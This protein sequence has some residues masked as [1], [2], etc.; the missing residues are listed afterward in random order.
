MLLIGSVALN[1]HLD[2]DVRVPADMD[3]VC[4]YDE[5]EDYSKKIP[6]KIA[7]YPIQQG[8]KFIMKSSEKIV[9]AEIAWPDSSSEHLLKVAYK[10][11]KP[12]DQFYIPSLNF[13]YMLKMSHKYLKD[14]PHFLKTMRDIQLM[15]QHGAFIEDAHMEFFIEREKA[16]Y[17]YKHPNLKVDKDNFFKND[18]VPYTYDHDSIHEAVKHLDRPAYTYFIIDGAQVQVD[19]EKFFSLPEHIKLL[20]VL[21]ESYVLALERAIIPHGKMSA[22]ES[23]DMA[24]MKVCTSITSGWWR[25]Y[26]WENYDKA[27]AMYDEEFVNRFWEAEKRGI[28]KPFKW[29]MYGW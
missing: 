1:Y 5:F 25:E 4:T 22:K 16:T 27:Q 9:E 23:F 3:I 29:S 17:A 13:L 6:N 15:R 21:E 24:L 19:K 20:S 8:K 18:E 12:F 28:V 10:D 11:A 2:E 7:Q 26:A 14:S